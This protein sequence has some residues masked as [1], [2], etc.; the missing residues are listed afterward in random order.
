MHSQF[1]SFFACPDCKEDLVLKGSIKA[2]NR[3]VVGILECIHCIKTYPIT[4][5]VPRFSAGMEN[6]EVKTSKSFGFKWDKFDQIDSGCKQNF[7]DEL[8]PVNYKTFF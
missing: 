7:L 4:N 1:I 6:I 3:I 8:P 2:E 5:F